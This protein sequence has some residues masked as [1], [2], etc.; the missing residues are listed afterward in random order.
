MQKTTQEEPKI[1]NELDKFKKERE[2]LTQLR[3]KL[4][5]EDKKLRSR[6]KHI[7]NEKREWE[8]ESINLQLEN[9]LLKERL[10][11]QQQDELREND[12]STKRKR[13]G[14]ADGKDEPSS[15]LEKRKR[16]EPDQPKTMYGS[17]RDS[18]GGGP[19][20]NALARPE[21]TNLWA[22]LCAIEGQ[23]R[24]LVDGQQ[25][26]SQHQKA[27]LDRSKQSTLQT[28]TETTSSGSGEH[29]APMEMESQ[30]SAEPLR[31]Y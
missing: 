9:C 13:L 27:I 10:L 14:E 30:P 5:D 23:L 11:A 19:C 12:L 20:E 31:S 17:H 22:L 1:L 21:A 26:L 16:I 25:V 2:Q 8:E 6:E 4:N 7:L 24:L 15:R 29:D 28:T 18:D 3:K